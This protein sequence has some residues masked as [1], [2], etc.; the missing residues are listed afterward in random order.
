MPIT[1]S[2]KPSRRKPIEDML[3]EK[4]IT[5]YS[6]INPYR[7]V[8]MVEDKAEFGMAG[9]GGHIVFG[10]YIKGGHVMNCPGN[11]IARMHK[12]Q[13]LQYLM[14]HSVKKVAVVAGTNDL[15]D[16]NNRVKGGV[17]TITQR[18]RAL[19]RDL[20]DCGKKV[21]ISKVPGRVGHK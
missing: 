12:P 20:Q 19:V 4:K 13:I 10:V 2:S 8:A 17:Q 11:T 18:M 14:M 3:E 21:C 16:R 15:V 7:T 6:H 1:R 9:L 5:V